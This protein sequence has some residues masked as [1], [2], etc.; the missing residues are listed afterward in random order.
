MTIIG[1]TLLYLV[2][3]LTAVLAYFHHSSLR[4]EAEKKKNKFNADYD[5]D[6][7][8]CTVPLNFTKAGVDRISIN[9]GPEFLLTQWVPRSINKIVTLIASALGNFLYRKLER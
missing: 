7:T 2:A 1:S 4:E 8:D 5:P 6:Q 3:P 9:L